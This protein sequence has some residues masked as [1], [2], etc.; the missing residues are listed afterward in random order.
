MNLTVLLNGKHW[1]R[2]GTYEGADHLTFGR[3]GG[4]GG[5]GGL[6]F[7]WVKFTKKLFDSRTFKNVEQKILEIG[8]MLQAYFPSWRFSQKV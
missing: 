2:F 4:G 3:G 7:F 1:A 6:V 8:L 5:G